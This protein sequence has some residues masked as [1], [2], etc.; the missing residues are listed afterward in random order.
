MSQ[1][2]LCRAVPSRAWARVQLCTLGHQL[3]Q[4]P[5]PACLYNMWKSVLYQVL[6]SLLKVPKLAMY[7]SVANK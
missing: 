6:L 3:C 5:E 7:Y 4:D 2:M 1:A